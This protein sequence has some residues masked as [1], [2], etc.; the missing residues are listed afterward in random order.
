VKQLSSDVG[1]ITS[2]NQKTIVT[3][4]SVREMRRTVR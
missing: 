4:D 1:S 2:E 3:G